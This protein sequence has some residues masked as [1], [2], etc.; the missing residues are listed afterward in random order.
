MK[1][2]Y[3]IIQQWYLIDLRTRNIH[4]RILKY[5]TRYELLLNSKIVNPCSIFKIFIETKV[6]AMKLQDFNQ[7]LR[8]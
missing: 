7:I 4:Y 5:A 8:Q 6:A 2:G 1:F 3:F